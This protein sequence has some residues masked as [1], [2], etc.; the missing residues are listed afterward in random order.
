[1][2]AKSSSSGE[3]WELFCLYIAERR[4]QDLAYNLSSAKFC[5]LLMDSTMDKGNIENEMFLVL[6]SQLV[7]GAH[8]ALD[9][10][11][12]LTVCRPRFGLSADEC[13]RLVGI[14]TVAAGV[15]KAFSG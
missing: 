13:K 3:C 5:F 11:E 15:L 1:M 7:K 10:R 9:A 8:F 12:R 14:G 6:W 4:R 2:T